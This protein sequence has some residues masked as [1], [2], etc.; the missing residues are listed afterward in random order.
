MNQ[1]PSRGR[2]VGGHPLSFLRPHK[3]WN[4]IDRKSTRLNSSHLVISYAVFCLKK[5]KKNLVNNDRVDLLD[6]V[7]GQNPGQHGSGL[8]LS[9]PTPSFQ[10][11]RR[12][13]I[14]LLL[15]VQFLVQLI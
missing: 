1:E 14:T 10:T 7:V 12:V 9:S 13:S 6:A 5:K 8:R 3:N 2:L 15:N 11:T 4:C